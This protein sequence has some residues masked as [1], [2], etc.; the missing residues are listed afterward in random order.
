MHAIK[1]ACILDLGYFPCI[2]RVMQRITQGLA[3]LVLCTLGQSV[4]ADESEAQQSS[5]SFSARNIT[6]AEALDIICEMNNLRYELR[7]NYIV[8]LPKNAPVGG[9]H[10]RTIAVDPALVTQL[11]TMSGVRKQVQRDRQPRFRNTKQW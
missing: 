10:Q 6:L 1:R 8:L 9:L 7:G 5:V 3:M 2:L 4:Y 11:K